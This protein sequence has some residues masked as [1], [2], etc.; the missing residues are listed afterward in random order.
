MSK[1]LE[2][3]TEGD[4]LR[5]DFLSCPTGMRMARDVSI[6]VSSRATKENQEQS[7]KFERDE[8]T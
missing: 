7:S 6:F 1:I 2:T 4:S 8:W 3:F 5:F